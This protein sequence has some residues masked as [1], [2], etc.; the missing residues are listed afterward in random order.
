MTVDRV[1]FT[2]LLAGY[3]CIPLIFKRF[4]YLF[5]REKVKEKGISLFLSE[6]LQWLLLLQAD[7]P[8]R[9]SPGAPVWVAE[10]HVFEPSL[11]A[12]MG[13]LAGLWMGSRTA[14]TVFGSKSQP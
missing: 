3:F 9:D 4:V 7:A 12:F 8:G 6:W 5:E 11:T 13:V 2:L 14:W 1:T 10:E